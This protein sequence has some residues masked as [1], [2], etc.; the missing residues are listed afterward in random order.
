MLLLI[1]VLRCDVVERRE[2]ETDHTHFNL[3][4][5][6]IKRLEIHTQVACPR[7]MNG[8]T[9]LS[10]SLLFGSIMAS[11][12]AVQSDRRGPTRLGLK[13]FSS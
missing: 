1:L 13:P 10:I 7:A 8:F 9:I 4:I 2:L 6:E 5:Q 11:P 12:V 3:L